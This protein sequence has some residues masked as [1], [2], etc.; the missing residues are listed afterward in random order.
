MSPCISPQPSPAPCMSSPQSQS[1]CRCRW[2]NDIL[3][4][5]PGGSSSWPG[6]PGWYGGH[7]SPWCR[8]DF[9]F[10]SSHLGGHPGGFFLAVVSKAAVDSGVQVLWWDS[11]LAALQGLSQFHRMPLVRPHSPRERTALSNGTA[12]HQEPSEP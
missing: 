12:S 2:T 9:H 10:I 1:L 6:T 5:A 7:F 8:V 4:R 11:V 3:C